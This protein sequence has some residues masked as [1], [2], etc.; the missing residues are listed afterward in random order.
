MAEELQGQGWL[1][2]LADTFTLTHTGERAL[3]EGRPKK[4]G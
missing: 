4:L 3:E 1:A 2:L